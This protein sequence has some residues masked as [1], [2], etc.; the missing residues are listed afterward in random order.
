MR[1]EVSPEWQGTDKD[2]GLVFNFTDARAKVD[3]TIGTST[4]DKIPN[5]TLVF[6]PQSTW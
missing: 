4:T 3:V 1:V 6:N 2:V 5:G